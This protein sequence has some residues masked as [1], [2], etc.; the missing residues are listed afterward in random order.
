M[1][2]P[3]SAETK[4]VNLDFNKEFI[5]TFTQNI[6][7][8]NVVFINQTYHLDVCYISHYNAIYRQHPL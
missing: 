8:G 7:E 5:D 3:K 1:A 6:E 2:L 4:K